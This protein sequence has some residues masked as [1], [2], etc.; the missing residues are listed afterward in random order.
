MKYAVLIVV[1]G[2]LVLG[3]TVEAQ[4]PSQPD[5]SECTQEDLVEM[6]LC[7]IY[8]NATAT[9]VAKQNPTPSTPTAAPL[10][11]TITPTPTPTPDPLD[12]LL[13]P[14]PTRTPSA[15][16]HPVETACSD[17]ADLVHDSWWAMVDDEVAQDLM[18]K[19]QGANRS[20]LQARLAS[21]HTATENYPVI[22][23]AIGSIRAARLSTYGGGHEHRKT[24]GPDGDHQHDTWFN[25]ALIGVRQ[26]DRLCGYYGYEQAE[27]HPDVL[28]ERLCTR[29]SATKNEHANAFLGLPYGTCK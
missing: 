11:P 4:E 5:Y 21:I 10:T 17:F 13:L 7:Q 22:Y 14:D 6:F 29:A 2:M 27:V 16:T 18:Q 24:F 3:C 12:I 20:V 28:V 23:K 15:Q 8:V 19:P 26:V 25:G 9:A 1:I